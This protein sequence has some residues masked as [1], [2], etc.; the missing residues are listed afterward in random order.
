M[1]GD[2]LQV[3]GN[4][5]TIE[6]V[7]VM[8]E[9]EVTSVLEKGAQLEMGEPVRW[10]NLFARGPR[11]FPVGMVPPTPIGGGP[12]VLPH[13]IIQ[14]GQR[15]FIDTLVVLRNTPL[16]GGIVPCNYLSA[17]RFEYS[18]KLLTVHLN[19]MTAVDGPQIERRFVRNQCWY[20]NAFEIVPARPGI[21]EVYV[22]AR[23]HDAM[24]E[25]MAPFA[26]FATEILDMDF[27]LFSP[28]PQG[29]H[30]IS[31]SPI[32]YMVYE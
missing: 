3:K 15:A 28:M 27:N 4:P 1:G 24:E 9:E 23:I 16:P 32:R 17:A 13:K 29:P 7:E 10:W 26:A 19:S 5:L 11:Q 2:E 31:N 25:P 8:V 22:T 21:Y 6:Q 30:W 20:V 18:V 14:V 12:N